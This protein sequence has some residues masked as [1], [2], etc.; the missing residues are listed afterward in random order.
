MYFKIMS[1][2]NVFVWNGTTYLPLK[3]RRGKKI[4]ISGYWQS[5]D[6]FSNI[7]KILKEE[8]TPKVE[9]TEQNREFLKQI[10]ESN[11]ICLSIRR[12]DYVNNEKIKAFHF[13]CDDEYFDKCV[14]AALLD[15]SNPTLICF[16]DDTEWVKE[17]VKFNCKTIYESSGN[18]LTDKIILMSN[19]K[20]FILSNSSFS[21]W[22]E[23][24]SEN[25][26][27]NVYAPNL[28]YANG[29][30]ADIYQKYWKI[31]EVNKK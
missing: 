1:L 2:F 13:V 29:Q 11:S 30:K 25:K 21:W 16:S 27:K 12:G 6:Y 10:Q 5:P 18:S 7:D 9:I 4:F 8:F 20:H 17:N 24:L 28:W 23:Y 3:I 31:I 14:N 22:V 26:N 15:I 19:C